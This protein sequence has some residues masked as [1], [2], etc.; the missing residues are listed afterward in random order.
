MFGSNEKMQN[1]IEELPNNLRNAVGDTNK[2][3]NL[4][5]NQISDLL[6][7]KYMR[8]QVSLVNDI[9]GEVF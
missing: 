6:S 1:G 8:F 9:N 2:Y 4:T 7:T 5:K 3:I